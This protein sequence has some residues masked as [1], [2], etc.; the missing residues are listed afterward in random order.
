MIEDIVHG[1]FQTPIYQSK[2]D[3]EFTGLEK[4]FF[5]K[6]LKDSSP[7]AGNLTSVDSY[8]LDNPVLNNLKKEIF[9][10]IE[11]YYKVV[12][13]T[14]DKVTPYITQSWINGTKKGQYH[15]RHSHT[16]SII[17]G[18]VYIKAEENVDQIKFHDERY[19]N[20]FGNQTYTVFNSDSWSFPVKTR[21]I[22]L[23][24][25][26]LEHSVPIKETSSS[27]VSLSFNTFVK[28]V[29]GCNFSKS[30]IILE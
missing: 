6:C 19:P 11:N 24:P 9:L 17:S 25:S 7:N 26:H 2:L 18:V 28:G 14:Q 15:H 20:P 23:F 1:I 21:D 16:N 30:E 8:V 27:R 12:I 13:Q 5:E 29:L 3:R 22:F 4:H 10:L